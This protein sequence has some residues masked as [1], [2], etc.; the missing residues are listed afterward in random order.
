MKKPNRSKLRVIDIGQDAAIAG[1]I[2]S[3]ARGPW[4]VFA[5]SRASKRCFTQLYFLEQPLCLATWRGAVL[6]SMLVE[7]SRYRVPPYLGHNGGIALDLSNR[8]DADEIREL[9]ESNYRHYSL[10]RTLAV[11]DRS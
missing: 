8:C 11:L 3:A 2:L 10:K 9:I 1:D 5:V 6:Q 7:D 4:L